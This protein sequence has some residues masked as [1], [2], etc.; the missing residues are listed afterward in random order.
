MTVINLSKINHTR[1]Y[2]VDS[3][4]VN[5][6]KSTKLTHLILSDNTVDGFVRTANAIKFVPNSPRKVAFPAFTIN[7]SSFRIL[8][9]NA[10][11]DSYFN[12]LKE[13]RFPFNKILDLHKIPTQFNGK[14]ILID[15][16]IYRYTFNQYIKDK[17]RKPGASFG[18]FKKLMDMM[19]DYIP[20]G[21]MIQLIF[22]MA[23]EKDAFME[24]VLFFLQYKT[25]EMLTYLKQL[26]VVFV[27]RSGFVYQGVYTTPMKGTI[28][29]I[30]NKMN[31]LTS[32]PTEDL[33]EY[34]KV[35]TDAEMTTAD[36]A[37]L[38]QSTKLIVDASD[39]EQFEIDPSIL[40]QEDE[41]DTSALPDLDKPSSP[42]ELDASNSDLTPIPNG[43]ELTQDEKVLSLD[44]LLSM[45]VGDIAIAQLK[46]ENV[47]FLKKVMPQQEKVLAEL[48]K[49]A[50][51]LAAD[52]TLDTKV[53]PDNTIISEGIKSI[54]T[55]AI[56]SSYY[57]KQ[58]K[59]DILN[60][61]KSLNND[62]D[63]PVIVTKFEIKDS[64]SAL[65]K[66]DELTV[67]FMDKKYK[68][69]TFKVDVPRLS[70]DG[71]MLINGNKKFIAKQATPITVIKETNDRV[72]ITTNYR[73]TFLYRKG[74]KTSGHVD[75]I[76]RLISNQDFK[77][78]TR[79]YGNSTASN[80]SYPVSIPYNYLAKKYFK[81]QLN[82][83]NGI[84][85]YL[86]QQDIR[87]ALTE[88]KVTF[89]EDKYLPIGFRLSKGKPYDLLLEDITSREVFV[90]P[91]SRKEKATKYNS[92]LVQMIT[93]IITSTTDQELADSYKATK[94]SL[95]LSYTEIKI[96]STSMALGV[97]IAS[98]RGLIPAL[99]LYKVKYHVEDKRIAKKES[100]IVLAFKDAYLYIDTEFKPDIEIFVNGL[101]FLNCS[102]YS[103]GETGVFAPIFLDYL[104]EATGSRNTAKALMNFESSMLDPITMET[105]VSLNLPTN[106][107]ELLLYGNTLLGDFEH[108]RKNDMSHFRIR[109]SEVITVAVYNTLMDAYNNYKRSVRSGIPQ[110][111]STKKDAVLK[112]LQGMTNV[113]D[114]STLNPF[115]EAELKSKTTFKGPSGLNSSDAY[116]AEIRAYDKSMLGL[117]GIYTPIGP[118]V[119]VN[120]SLVLNPKIKTTRGFIQN[121]DLDKANASNLFSI[122]ELLN[123]F[124]AKHADSPRAIMATVQG[125]HL[126]PTFVQHP[127]VV[128]NGTDKALAHLV[129][130]DFAFKSSMDGVVTSIDEEKE[131]C[132]ITFT[133]GNTSVI[134]F[135]KKPAKNSGGGFFI[136]NKL[137]LM[138]GIKKGYK[139]KKGEILAI[140]DSFFKEMLDGSI[141]FAGGRL[142][143]IAV[144]ALPETFEDSA[145]IT[146]T[147]VEEMASKVINERPAILS[148]NSRI[149]KM[150]K[151]GD[152]VEVNDALII[153]EEVGSDEAT[154]LKALEKLDSSTQSTIEEIARSTVKAKFTGEIFDIRIY[155]N[156]DLEKMHPSLRKIVEAYIKKYNA[157]G[158]II[159]KIKSDEIIQQ[160]STDKIDALKIMGNDVDGVVIQFFIAHKDKMKVGDKLTFAVALKAILAETIE[161]G[162]EP[163]T[164]YRP[165][166]ELSAVISPMSLVSRMVP[167]LYL[168]GFSTKVVIELERQCIDLL[169]E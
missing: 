161:E 60:V 24:A 124:T 121:F 80:L 122:G 28:L 101:L 104:Q 156:C 93:D 139:F 61:V 4:M 158:N 30:L 167:D 166:E 83:D 18:I 26:D 96:V 153:F 66:T 130:Q 132:I 42:I 116:T 133:D 87:D 39:K 81:I 63:F 94:P 115:L 127:Y 106:F 160:P 38:D 162:K 5:L 168:L 69:S 90:N 98:Y 62:P 36:K 92:S 35:V 128:G 67:E 20:K 11:R 129:G 48:E 89:N 112:A 3:L 134:D 147:V 113:E 47:E 150:A 119:G 125:K 29:N 149:T 154:A 13:Q 7:D 110:P 164:D 31:K 33:G 105:L 43:L 155:Y 117:Y 70:H 142:S 75:R 77:S 12:E 120:R 22:D 58:Y 84:L 140:D 169:E 57:T 111:I 165:E 74:E 56:T 10:V 51:I 100:E 79:T 137:T 17:K 138:K 55:N 97:L 157:K 151:I 52:K 144:A 15:V 32:D 123:V 73:K 40:H 152:M 54:S 108:H 159:S 37:L 27:S 163:Y 145:I 9:N 114:Y 1:I 34:V 102:T 131:L 141:G 46:A 50:D 85:L 95:S 76:L 25:D 21:R 126:T 53:I 23:A 68:K 78:I 71:F 49:E 6:P 64:S 65:S 107:P 59:R 19:L 103:L 99:D 72:Q 136:Q 86:N 91:I 146:S 148:K 8:K 88:M 109:D 16:S 41:H 45:N 118:E 2:K 44:N 143:K 135:S 14:P 82:G